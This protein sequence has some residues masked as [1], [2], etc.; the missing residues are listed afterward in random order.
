MLLGEHSHV[1]IQVL[2]G[3]GSH[4]SFYRHQLPQPIVWLLLGDLDIGD[5]SGSSFYHAFEGF[6]KLV[7]EVLLIVNLHILNEFVELHPLFAVSLF[8][9]HLIGI[10]DYWA[11]EKN[12]NGL[13]LNYLDAELLCQA[14]Q[15]CIFESHISELLVA[16]EMTKISKRLDKPLSPQVK[17]F[18]DVL[19]NF[20]DDVTILYVG[21]QAAIQRM[22][23]DLNL[24][25]RAY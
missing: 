14:N 13:K 24:V 2:R 21:L 9:N 16:G 6:S 3:F 15:V 5:L 8:I 12:L 11:E 7:F 4:C 23:I 22:D 17:Q 10:W 1:V 25:V 20:Q 18:F 19:Q